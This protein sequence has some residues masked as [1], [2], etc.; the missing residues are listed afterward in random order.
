MKKTISLLLTAML[1]ICAVPM[2][3]F[4][5]GAI[6]VTLDEKEIVFPDAKPF[7]NKDN[8][9]LVPLSPIATAMGLEVAWDNEAEI[10]T[11][12]HTFT[13]ENSPAFYEKDAKNP[14][15]CY[16]GKETIAFR[17]GKKEA[18]HTVYYYDLKDTARTTPASEKMWSKTITMDTEAVIQDQRTY[19]PVKYLAETLGYD[20][21]WDEVNST[22]ILN[23]MVPN[24]MV[25]AN[26][27]GN[28]AD[29]YA[30]GFFKARFAPIRGLD[31]MAVK[32]VTV[33]GN[34][35][36]YEPFTEA[37]LKDSELE[38]GGYLAGGRIKYEFKDAVYKIAV[39]YEMTF[40]DG[41]KTADVYTFDYDGTS[42][43]GGM[44]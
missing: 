20:V 1:L 43:F 32:S 26:L 13:A 8:R 7:V 11:F 44:L 21:I 18:V 34:A 10:A 39:S 9:T 19:A 28:N 6:H 27:L 36:A 35:A 17:I 16:L 4:A 24:S 5:A 42:G 41:S 3:A 22:V 30:I 29:Y 40:N 23:T 33:D 31:K 25:T 14:N 38:L 2:S 15:G 37:E 12:T